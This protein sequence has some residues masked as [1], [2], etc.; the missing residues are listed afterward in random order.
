M[1]ISGPTIQAFADENY[2]RFRDDDWE[3]LE[4]LLLRHVGEN[5]SALDP[6][7]YKNPAT[8]WWLS[9]FLGGWG[10]DRFYLGQVGAGL[11]KLLTEG[12]LFFW[13]FIDLFCIT[14]ATRKRNAKRMRQLLGEE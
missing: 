12:G 1:L 4:A 14:T 10:V 8:V 13:Y 2:R 9:F 7:E 6:E 5:N 3:E 11:V